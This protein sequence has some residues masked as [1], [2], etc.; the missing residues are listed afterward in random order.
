MAD[1][2]FLDQA[3]LTHLMEYIQTYILEIEVD[4]TKTGAKSV[5]ITHP[6]KS[7]TITKTWTDT[8]NPYFLKIP[9][10]YRGK[11]TLTSGKITKETE[12]T[13]VNLG[14]VTPVRMSSGDY[15]DWLS[16]IGE[17]DNYGSLDNLLKNEVMIRKLMTCH[18]SVD[19]LLEWAIADIDDANVTKILNNDLVAKWATLRDY[20]LD[21]LSSNENLKAKM[22]TIGKYFYGEWSLNK[23]IP[24]LTANSTPYGDAI[25][26]SVYSS[27]YPFF[28]AFDG[29]TGAWIASGQN[30]ACGFKY[31]GKRC[32]KAVSYTAGDNVKHSV[33]EFKI[34]A[35]NDGTSWV[36]IFHET[37]ND[38][39]LI[40]RYFEFKE[41]SNSY[42]YWR[43]FIISTYGGDECGLSNLQFYEYSPKGLIPIMTSDTAPYGQLIA[44]SVRSGF[45]AYQVF[46][47]TDN[48]WMGTSY[49]NQYIGYRFVNPVCVKKMS[50]RS[51]VGAEPQRGVKKA[52]VEA[53]ND[54]AN[55]TVIKPD[56]IDGNTSDN[57]VRTIDIANDKYYLYYRL[58]IYEGNSSSAEYAPAIS[59][60]QFYGRE[61]K[62]S[63]PDMTSNTAP[64]G[65]AFGA[66]RDANIWAAFSRLGGSRYADTIDANGATSYISYK[67][68]RP[69]CVKYVGLKVYSDLSRITRIDLEGSNDRNTWKS[70]R[71]SIPIS[72]LIFEKIDND[73]SYL[74]YRLKIS[75]N[76]NAG[77]QLVNFYGSDYSEREFG[78][79]YTMKYIYDHGLE[80]IG[81]KGL[82][83][84]SSA[85]FLKESNQLYMYKA[86]NGTQASFITT[87]AINLSSYNLERAVSG[88]KINLTSS[89]AT[90][91]T[92][93]NNSN[94]AAYSSSTNIIASMLPGNIV[95][96]ISS[97]N[98]NQYPVISTN[99]GGN[100]VELSIEEW[101]LE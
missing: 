81:L 79:G 4:S 72:S 56:F 39:T 12:L 96:N 74:Y 35:S 87:D 61:L 66:M 15:V 17:S 27:S 3:G 49:Y 43:M 16:S 82:T 5:T 62:I 28:K 93:S 84:S 21:K 1:K 24:N 52:K 78:S 94:L 50:Y 54:G 18:A 13:E 57:N 14:K 34:Q 41:N 7:W 75:N 71:S 20:A 95:N 30:Q 25:G 33:K 55:W 88:N 10:P 11:Y 68:T 2:Y 85:Y 38:T 70:I 8:T 53:S 9:V 45:P 90:I 89:N 46:D 40:K 63:V 22:E 92:N 60:L 80:L 99:G 19:Y 23:T 29:G 58:Y 51:S 26:T 37:P 42:Q 67:F 32:I 36:D 48:V 100:A 101:W 98:N 86:A 76:Y 47:S 44:S 73:I 69:V 31:T 59:Y 64:Y 65:E 83:M 6:E 77:I 97:I 91:A